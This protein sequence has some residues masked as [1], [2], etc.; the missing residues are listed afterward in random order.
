MEIIVYTQTDNSQNEKLQREIIRTLDIQPV[1]AFDFKSLFDTL[2]YRLSR[3]IIIV[4]F[5][6]F[7]DELDFLVSNKNKLFNSRC[8]MILS[9]K[10]ENL[11]SKVLSL[12]PRY[13]AHPNQ[14]FKDISAVL[15]KMIQNNERQKK[16]L[17]AEESQR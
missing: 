15:N 11:T 7:E 12:S 1:M 17:R 16:N 2:R 8:I 10:S 13:I 3:E 5:I 14:N 9:D 6:S 4:F